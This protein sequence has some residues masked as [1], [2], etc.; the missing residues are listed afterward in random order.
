MVVAMMIL[1]VKLHL[2]IRA[3]YVAV[4]ASLEEDLRYLVTI[5]LLLPLAERQKIY[6]VCPILSQFYRFL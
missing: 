2:D 4:L 6:F 5:M 1:Y 3:Q